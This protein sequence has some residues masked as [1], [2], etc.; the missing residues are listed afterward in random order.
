VDRRRELLLGVVSWCE[1]AAAGLAKEG[2]WWW[3]A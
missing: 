3:K 2:V 1:E